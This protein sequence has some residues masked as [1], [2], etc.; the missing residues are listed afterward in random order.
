LGEVL[1]VAAQ[2]L[3]AGALEE[4]ARATV[5]QVKVEAR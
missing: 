2:V 5:H 1:V 3:A 4:E